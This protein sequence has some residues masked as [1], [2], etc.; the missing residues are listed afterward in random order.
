MDARIQPEEGDLDIVFFDAC[1][2]AKR[3]RSMRSLVKKDANF[4]R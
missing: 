4:L 1:I 2:T 3:N